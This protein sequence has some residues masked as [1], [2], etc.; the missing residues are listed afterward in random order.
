MAVALLVGGIQYPDGFLMSFASAGYIHTALRVL[1]VV[2]LIVVLVSQPP[3]SP[4]V[5]LILGLVSA[6]LLVGGIV[7]IVDYRIG[8]LD[9]MLYTQVA[10]ILAIEAL[11]NKTAPVRFVALA[12]AKQ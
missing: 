1:V 12:T 5:R 6:T 7:S 2:G 8:I 3:R 9:V 10:I 4:Q 11:E